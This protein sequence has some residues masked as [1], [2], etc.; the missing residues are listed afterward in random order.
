[1]FFFALIVLLCIFMTELL[2]DSWFE[3]VCFFIQNFVIFVFS[4]KLTYH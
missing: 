2:I 4:V 3:I 1:M